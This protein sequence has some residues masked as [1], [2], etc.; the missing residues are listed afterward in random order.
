MLLQAS[1]TDFLTNFKFDIMNFI[2]IFKRHIIVNISGFP[3]ATRTVLEGYAFARWGRLR[4]E[5]GPSYQ[6]AAQRRLLVRGRGRQ[7]L[8][9]HVAVEALRDEG[10]RGAL[11]LD[12]ALVQLGLRPRQAPQDHVKAVVPDHCNEQRLV[13]APGSCRVP[14]AWSRDPPHC[15]LG[16]LHPCIN[17]HLSPG[18]SSRR[19]DCPGS[20]PLH[21]GPRGPGHPPEGQGPAGPD[22]SG[23]AN[24]L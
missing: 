20:L 15:V 22:R 11:L 5:A 18:G 17:L 13:W 19:G 9:A 7:V 1:L 14:Q 4:E 24:W 10:G 2:F 23:A 21:W 6:G 3:E 16:A 12:E 8:A